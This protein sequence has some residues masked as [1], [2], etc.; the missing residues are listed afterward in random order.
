MPIWARRKDGNHNRIR[1]AF[2]AA[3][4]EICETYRAPRTPD[5]FASRAGRT[6]AVQVKA[7]KGT[8][9]AEQRDFAKRWAGEYALLTDPAQVQELSR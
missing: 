3:G 8:E 5:F 6:I 1:N 4:W 7:P 2:I 9:T